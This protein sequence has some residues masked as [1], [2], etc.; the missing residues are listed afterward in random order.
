MIRFGMVVVVV[1]VVLVVETSGGVDI[2]W[3]DVVIEVVVWCVTSE[4]KGS[5]SC[6]RNDSGS[7]SGSKSLVA[8]TCSGSDSGSRSGSGTGSGSGNG[9][10][11]GSARC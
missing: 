11:N 7:G 9:N 4:A 10:G 6:Y 2:I 1:E 3:R 5:D 8:G